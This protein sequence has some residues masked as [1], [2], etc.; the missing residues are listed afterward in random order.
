[1]FW[2]QGSDTASLHASLRFRAGIADTTLPTLG[3]TRLAAQAVLCLVEDARVTVHGTLTSLWTSFDVSGEPE[4][5]AQVLTRLSDTIRAASAAGTSAAEM[6]ITEAERRPQAGAFALAMRWLFGATGYGLMGFPEFGL[7]TARPEAVWDW[8]HT[9][10]TADNAVLCLDGRPPPGLRLD[11]PPGPHVPPLPQAQPLTEPGAY[12]AESPDVLASAVMPDVPAT[13][14]LLRVLRERVD[15]MLPSD[16]WN[17][18]P[19][20][21]L[22][23]RIGVDLLV[24]L[25]VTA[26]GPY[27]VRVAES[28]LVELDG[29]CDSDLSTPQAPSVPTVHDKV[30]AQAE[31]HF[32]DIPQRIGAPADVR[33][34]ARAFRRGLYLGVP[35][36]ADLSAI[37]LVFPGARHDSIVDGVSRRR[38]FGHGDRTDAIVISGDQGV[39]LVD[40]DSQLTV[41]WDD[42][43]AALVGDGDTRVLIRTDGRMLDLDPEQWQRGADLIAHVDRHV[44]PA[45]RIPWPMSGE[46]PDPVN[47]PDRIAREAR[48]PRSVLSHIAVNGG[49]VLGALLVCAT[50][51]PVDLS[52]T[53]G[54]GP[55]NAVFFG[56]LTAVCFVIL[57]HTVLSMWG[58]I[59]YL[60]RRRAR[61]TRALRTTR[62]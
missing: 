19:S 4:A 18:Y 62:V 22:S 56:I 7:A 25:S 28:I 36:D 38:R 33:S 8:A 40:N 48:W 12:S 54:S 34:A 21:I 42:M 2:A 6:V 57:V 60:R 30:W 31:G 17:T 45:Q 26:P 55:A 39:S 58:L 37:P 16:T 9:R 53:G 51:I 23:E 15:R 32:L 5:V 43:A 59:H 41:L 47:L 20:A 27:A 3:W 52:L 35:S 44:S 13:H 11:L 10:F 49:L 14:E 29:V 46:A 61:R 24:G 1:M 50:L